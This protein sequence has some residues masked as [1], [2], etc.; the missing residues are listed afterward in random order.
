LAVLRL[1]G[2]GVTDQEAYVANRKGFD[3]KEYNEAVAK[4]TR[5]ED[6]GSGKPRWHL[7]GPDCSVV[8][9]R[10]KLIR[11]RGTELGTGKPRAGVY[12][13]LSRS[14]SDL[15]PVPIGATTDKD[16]HY[17]IHGAH[18]T[19]R[20]MVEVSGAATEGFMA[21]Q[22]WGDD[23]PGYDPVTIDIGVKKGVI[24]T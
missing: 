11:G 24:V 19:G 12:V 6:L 5:D 10:E 17:E 8:A 18:K 4:N 15:L 1:S 22:A 9:E 21:S 13:T 20:Y 23:A 2:G 14:G 7:Y 16:G 3:P